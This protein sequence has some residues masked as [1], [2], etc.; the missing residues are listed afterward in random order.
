MTEPVLL[1][2]EGAVATVMINRPDQ[3]NALDAATK[4]V[5]LE[6]LGRPPATTRSGRSC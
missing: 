6:R 2:I 4:A 1:Q 5:L 3:R